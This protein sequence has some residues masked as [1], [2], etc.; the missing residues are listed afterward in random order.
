MRKRKISK[1]LW[2]LFL[3][4]GFISFSYAILSGNLFVSNSK[5]GNFGAVKQT[6]QSVIINKK[7][8]SLTLIDPART[9]ENKLLKSGQKP[10]IFVQ[11]QND[12]TSL[13][14]IATTSSESI[15]NACAQQEGS[16][17]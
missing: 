8:T 16:A 15:D 9:R 3:I 5:L 14:N 11:Q 7:D 17:K 12:G 1:K 10:G 4:L 13:C 6:Q 2:I